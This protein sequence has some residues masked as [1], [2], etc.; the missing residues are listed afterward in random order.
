M[1]ELVLAP[2]GMR[3]STFEQPLP[4]ELEPAAAT[5]HKGGAAIK[6]RWHI[7]PEMAAAGLWTTPSDLARFAIA[8][9]KQLSGEAPPVLS[10]A[11]A[12]E[13][14]KPQTG[15]WGLG[16]GRDGEGDSARFSHGGIDEGFDAVL[17][18]YN[19]RGQGVVVMANA[20]TENRLTQEV[21]RAVAKVYD[22]PNF[23][24]GTAQ[25]R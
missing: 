21:M 2:L 6:G 3:H 11:M 5:A 9:Q 12:V 17:V 25:P 13:M 4:R 15:T 7:Y 24:P 23:L 18:A 8:V 1:K 22:W 16:F 10:K 20:N 14:L 19:T